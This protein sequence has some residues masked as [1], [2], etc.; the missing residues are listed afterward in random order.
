[1]V[2]TSE[3]FYGCLCLETTSLTSNGSLPQLRERQNSHIPLPEIHFNIWEEGTGTKPFLDIGVMLA[4]NDPAELIEIFLPWKLERGKIEDLSPRILAPCGVSAIFNEAWTSSSS[5]HNPGGYVTR[6]DGSVFSIVPY[7]QPVVQ[8]RKH[9]LGELHSIVLDI[10]QLRTTSQTTAATVL[11]NLKLMY[12]RIRVKDVPQ[13]FYRVGFDQGDALGGGTLNRTEIIDFRLNVRRGVPSAIESFLHG[14]FVEFSKV[15]LFLM[16]SR[17]QDIVFEDKLFKACRSLEDEKFWAEY[18]LPFLS[19]TKAKDK[20]LR[21]IKGSLGYQWKKTPDSNQAEVSEFGMLARFKSFKMRKRAIVLFIIAALILGVA[22]NGMYDFIKGMF[23]GSQAVAE[24]C[25]VNV[26]YAMPDAPK[27]LVDPKP[28][29]AT[30]KPY[31]KST[32]HSAVK[33]AR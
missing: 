28:S 17:D 30:A 2:T 4:I 14:R 23:S 16:K 26:P 8:S 15:Q 33:E 6:N 32:T 20:S 1:M 3:P 11:S 13:Q 18:I 29:A 9:Q 24:N 19:T 27:E 12:V 7:D 21:Q 31:E 25:Y 22:G 5:T 10:P